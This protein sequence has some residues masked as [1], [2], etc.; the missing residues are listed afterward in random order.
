M[1]SLKENIIKIWKN[2]GQILEGITNSVFKREDVEEIAKHRLAI[3]N[4]C[5]LFDIAGEGCTMPGTQPCCNEKKGGCGC[6][7]SL[8]TR[9]L[10]SACPQGKWIEE[11][12]EEEEDKLRQK[13]GL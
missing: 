9:A 5:D 1:S 7:L 8:K 12:T 11:L 4:A 2:K 3:C 6:S 10:S 13:L